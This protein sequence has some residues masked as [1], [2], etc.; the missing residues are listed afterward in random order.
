MRIMNLMKTQYPLKPIFASALAILLLAHHVCAQNQTAQ[1][2]CNPLNIDYRFS[3]DILPSHRTAADPVIVTY[4]GDYYLFASKS[5]GYWWSSDFQNWNFVE[6][7][8]DI[9]IENYA[10]AI[11]VVGDSML[12][13]SSQHGDLY[14]S[15]D[16][17]SGQWK[18]IGHPWKWKD[19]ALFIDDDGRV[20]CYYGLTRNGSIKVVELDPKNNFEV[21]GDEIICFSADFKSHG[22][23]KRGD[24]NEL[25]ESPH[26]EGAWMTKHNGT[27]YLDYSVPGTQY[28]SYAIGCYSAP[29][30]TGPFTFCPNSPTTARHLGFVTGVGHGCTFKDL[31]G[32]YWIATTVVVSVRHR[33][34]RR[35]AVFPL[36]YDADG[37]P[38]TLTNFGDYPQYLPGVNPHPEKGNLTGWNLL[39]RAKN[40]T[41]SSSIDTLP[42]SRAF[43][44]NIKTWWSAQSD[45]T[46]EWL[47]VDL[48]RPCTIRAVQVNFAEQETA[49]QGRKEAFAQKYLLEASVDGQ[50]WETIHQKTDQKDAPHDYVE[51]GKPVTAKFIRI[52]N[53]GPAAGGGKFAIRDLRVFGDATIKLPEKVQKVKVSR[54][55][56][57]RRSATIQWEPVPNV[58]GYQIRYGIAPDKLYGHYQVFS[59][60]TNCTINSLN[61]DQDYIFV[62]DSYNEAGI[63]KGD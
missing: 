34:E 15:T 19:P 20:Y 35:L 43:D 51:L 30:P 53:Q 16:P 2:F 62:V 52:T 5:G 56:E 55:H 6:P 58:D 7:K 32:N 12:Y 54:N 50:I 33:F 61:T 41:A 63:T 18:R 4:K 27:Y 25:E 49:A 45:E 22:F 57:D 40:A 48:E 21:I 11:L 14:V 10:P 1:T 23:E 42:P 38:H 44:E 59:E 37:L 3:L 17:K 39:S 26:I 24:N 28:R 13:T 60:E 9:Q 29:S 8:T 47:A 31:K 46:G 36:N